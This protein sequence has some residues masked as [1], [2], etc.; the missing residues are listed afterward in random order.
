MLS[1]HKPF[2]QKKEAISPAVILFKKLCKTVQWY[3][4]KH[5]RQW[6][7]SALIPSSTLIE[8]AYM[9]VLRTGVGF[10]ELK[11]GGPRACPVGP[12]M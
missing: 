4:L 3:D 9:S 6:V 2:P 12:H 8:G 7:Q 1:F 5:C 10:P 11:V